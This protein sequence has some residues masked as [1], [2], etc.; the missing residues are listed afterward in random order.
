MLDSVIKGNLFGLMVACPIGFATENCPLGKMRELSRTE[1]LNFFMKLS[2]AEAVKINNY[3][4]GCL[5]ERLKPDYSP[6]YSSN[7]D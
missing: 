4:R 3:H 2:L 7:S 5:S 6:R 1:Q